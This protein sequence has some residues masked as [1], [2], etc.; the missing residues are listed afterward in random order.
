MK[1][2]TH[3]GSKEDHDKHLTFLE[4]I[5]SWVERVNCGV[6]FLVHD[7]FL[8]LLR[9]IE[10]EVKEMLTVDFLIRY[11]G[12]D[13]KEATMAKLNANIAIQKLWESISRIQ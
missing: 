7:E 6:L 9:K 11:Y 8:T 13:V 4:Y 10:R 3:W 5:K 2:L 1:L 12:E